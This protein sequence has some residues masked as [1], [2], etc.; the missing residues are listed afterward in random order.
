MT[1]GSG[2]DAPRFTLTNLVAANIRLRDAVGK[3]PSTFG[4]AQF[5]GMIGDEIEDLREAGHGWDK[6]AALVTSATGTE[7]DS[8]TIRAN[9]APRRDPKGERQR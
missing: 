9:H 1:G 3:R 6:I 7:I 5:V 2:S 8:E 4:A